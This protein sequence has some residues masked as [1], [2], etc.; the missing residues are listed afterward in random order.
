M[1][2]KGHSSLFPINNNATIATRTVSPTASVEVGNV[3]HS[4]LGATWTFRGEEGGV[5]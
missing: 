1:V 3:L 2:G 4:F 5:I